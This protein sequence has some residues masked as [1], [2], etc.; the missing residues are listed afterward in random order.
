MRLAW[1]PATVVATALATSS[2]SWGHTFPSVRTVVVQVERCE[3]AVLV[4]YR[5]ASGEA[6]KELLTR[7]A[8]QPKPQGLE[9]LRTMMSTQALAPLTVS[10]DGTPL[11]PTSV[12]AKLGTE[13]GGARPM[14]VVLLSYPLPVGTT[15]SVSSKDSRTT[16]ISWTDHD[17][18]RVALAH[19]PGQGKWFPAVASF[20]LSLTP[21]LG[22]SPCVPSQYSLPLSGP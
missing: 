14:I 18:G 16:R 4:G 1:L 22:G 15:L 10:V 11:V 2:V 20:L 17:S 12:R 21:P 9:A 13:P 7:A 6:T 5:P 8:S 19:A 3:V